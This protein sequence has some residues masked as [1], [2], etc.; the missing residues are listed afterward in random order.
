MAS[1]SKKT[2]VRRR[3]RS[4][5]MG[6]KRKRKNQLYGSTSAEPRVCE[7]REDLV[8][9]D[10][11]LGTSTQAQKKSH[12]DESSNDHSSEHKS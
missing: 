5:K 12:T 10:D 4:L 1:A 2:K 8:A 7:A 11:S 6:A 9:A 3:L